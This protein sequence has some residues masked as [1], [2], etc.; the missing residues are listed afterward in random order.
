MRSEAQEAAEEALSVKDLLRIIYKHKWMLIA[1]TLLCGAVATIQGLRQTPIYRASTM[2]QVERN[3]ARIVS[4]NRDVDSTQ[5]TWDDGSFLRTQMELLRSR[6]LAERVIDEMGLDP[7]RAGVRG[8]SAFSATPS[9]PL[10]SSPGRGRRARGRG[11]PGRPSGTRR[12]RAATR[13]WRR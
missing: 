4:F 1:V 3:V 7:N 11:R 10:M 2:L 12:G 8:G 13:R 5:E 6:S 9:A